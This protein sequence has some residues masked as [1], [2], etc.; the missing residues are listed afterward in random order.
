MNEVE[1]FVNVEEGPGG[2]G[3]IN[4]NGEGFVVH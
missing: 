4:K 3:F 1:P 2:D